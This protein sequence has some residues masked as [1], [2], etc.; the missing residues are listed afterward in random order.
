MNEQ[1]AELLGDALRG[2]AALK[3]DK[4]FKDSVPLVPVVDGALFKNDPK[5]VT[6]TAVSAK[7]D[8]LYE[9][10]FTKP[11]LADIVAHFSEYLANWPEEKEEK[12]NE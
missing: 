8:E 6:I 5:L 3:K 9:V 12:T 1:Y 10:A 4:R 7:G 2:A 11:M